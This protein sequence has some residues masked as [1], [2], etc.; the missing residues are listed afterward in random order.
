MADALPTLEINMHHQ[1]IRPRRA[2]PDNEIERAAILLP[3][4]ATIYRDPRFVAVVWSVDASNRTTAQV[5]GRQRRCLP[6]LARTC[7]PRLGLASR[8][9]LG[10]SVTERCRPVAS[11]SPLGLNAH[12]TMDNGHTSRRSIGLHGPSAVG[13]HRKLCGH[14]MFLGQPTAY[15]Y[16]SSGPVSA[17]NPFKS[18][19]KGK[20]GT[21]TRSRAK[22]RRGAYGRALHGVL[23]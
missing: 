16:V 18:R 13:N 17:R 22:K 12:N 21:L 23:H 9:L 1:N 5:L 3:E 2:L 8:R 4:H 19:R 20:W 6:F 10:A 7:R 14:P 15:T 11:S